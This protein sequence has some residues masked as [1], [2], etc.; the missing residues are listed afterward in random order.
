MQLDGPY[1]L[2]RMADLAR[3]AL[4]PIDL[5]FAGIPCPDFSASQTVGAETKEARWGGFDEFVEMLA[6]RAVRGILDASVLLENV[7]R[8]ATKYMT[9]EKLNGLQ[10]RAGMHAKLFT[11]QANSF[12]CGTRRERTILVGFRDPRHLDAF[13]RGPKPTSASSAPLSQF[14]NPEYNNPMLHEALFLETRELMH[15]LAAANALQ[16]VSPASNEPLNVRTRSN[17]PTRPSGTGGTFV[18]LHS[19]VAQQVTRITG[20]Q[21]EGFK[22]WFDV[23]PALT[24]AVAPA[25]PIMRRLH[26]REEL[27]AMGWAPSELPGFASRADRRSYEWVADSLCPPV[28]EAFVARMVWA[29]GKPLPSGVT[30]TEAA[31]Q[32]V[33]RKSNPQR[34]EYFKMKAP[35]APGGVAHEE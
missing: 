9:L 23:S 34:V 11:V 20:Q 31:P 25:V 8:F 29:M 17:S 28:F 33:Q 13:G 1:H 2:T 30:V 22:T 24:S 27:R 10:R 14:I 26:P 3:A 21:L 16:I 7:P 6:S 35:E 32:D 5:M 18:C 19:S 15:G 12:G 4:Y